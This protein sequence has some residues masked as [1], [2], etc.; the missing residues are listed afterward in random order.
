MGLRLTSLKRWVPVVVA[1]GTVAASAP[2]QEKKLETPQPP[3]SAREKPEHTVTFSFDKKKWGE[4]IDWFKTE[5]GLVFAGTITPTGSV[6]IKPNPG[7][8]YT[9]PEVIDLLNEMLAPRYV[10]IRREQTFTIWPAGEP[11]E[12]QDVARITE[13]ELAKRGKTEVVQLVVSLGA[14]NADETVPQLKVMLSS[15]GKI[16]PLGGNSVIVQDKA[17]NVR[18]IRKEIDDLTEEGKQL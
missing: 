6:T 7:K 15:F 1:A 18:R 3:G 4:V 17:G 13:E 5:S 12:S 16:S 11:I 2:A 14:L 8:K 9:I 10:I